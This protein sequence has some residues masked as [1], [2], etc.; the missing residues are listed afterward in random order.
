MTPFYLADGMLAM[1]RMTARLNRRY[2]DE[3]LDR[4][5]RASFRGGGRWTYLRKNIQQALIPAL[6]SNARI[7]AA[8]PGRAKLSP[9]EY[10]CCITTGEYLDGMLS[11]RSDEFALDLGSTLR[12]NTAHRQESSCPVRWLLF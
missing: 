4:K 1:A 2:G 6:A 11:H 7:I 5:Q 8:E 9:D 10:D 12:K 3:E